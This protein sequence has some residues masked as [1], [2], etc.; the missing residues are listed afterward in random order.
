MKFRDAAVLTLAF[1]AVAVA[2]TEPFWAE[3]TATANEA[4]QALQIQPT[5]LGASGYADYPRLSCPTSIYSTKF[6][7]VTKSGDKVSGVFCNGPFSKA[8]GLEYEQEAPAGGQIHVKFK[9]LG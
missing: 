5:K 3:D 2:A 9:I 8:W 4:L 7:G 1:G 6:E